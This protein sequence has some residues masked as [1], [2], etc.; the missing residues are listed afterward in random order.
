MHSCAHTG[1]LV[2]V[3]GQ[4]CTHRDAYAHVR[5]YSHICICVHVC[6]CRR[7]CACIHVEPH[8][9]ARAP[10]T[11]VH[12]SVRASLCIHA[13]IHM[14]VRAHPPYATHLQQP[15]ALRSPTNLPSFCRRTGLD[16]AA[17]AA[18]A[19]QISSCHQLSFPAHF[20]I[21]PCLTRRQQRCTEL[22][23]RRRNLCKAAT[24]GQG[25][26]RLPAARG[27]NSSGTR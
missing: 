14:H 11:G 23:Q 7:A 27:N 16:A 25:R 12:N 2:Y 17:A 1:G 20:L 21:S 8:A 24:R 26:I 10:T 3:H 19:P 9:A 6:A 5:I 18:P 22:I 15:S 13:C 4:L